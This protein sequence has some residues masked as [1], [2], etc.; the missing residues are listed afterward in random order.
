MYGRRFIWFFICYKGSAGVPVFAGNHASGRAGQQFD[1]FDS[2]L[3]RVES[4]STH[5]H[6]LRVQYVR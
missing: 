6:S 5:N 1:L 4:V 2:I 3:G